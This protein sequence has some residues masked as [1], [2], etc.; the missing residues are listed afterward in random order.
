[1]QVYTI[2]ELEKLNDLIEKILARNKVMEGLHTE[3]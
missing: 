2:E 1:M 3:I